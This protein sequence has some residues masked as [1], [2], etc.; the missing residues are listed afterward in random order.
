M[1][2]GNGVWREIEVKIKLRNASGYDKAAGLLLDLKAIAEERG[3]T[4]D[5]IRRLRAIRERHARKGRFIKRLETL[6]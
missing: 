3:T 6:G 5:F 4:E 2:R 1:Q